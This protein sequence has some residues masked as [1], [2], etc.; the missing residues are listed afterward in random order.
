MPDIKKDFIDKYYHAAQIAAHGSKILPDTIIAAAALE[1]NFGRSG[2]SS[3]YN[4]FFGR[5]PEKSYTGKVVNMPTKEYNKNTKQFYTIQ[6]PFK[7]YPTPAD[8]F[9]DYV[10]LLSYS[11]RYEKVPQATNA[12]EQFAAIQAAGYATDPKYSSKLS[13][14][15]DGLKIYIP[16]V[17]LG[18]GFFVLIG[19]LWVLF[20]PNRTI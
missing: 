8:A 5:K 1:S 19:I 6:Q 11:K 13:S 10:K 3:Q 12:K 20:M 2:L 9:K 18:I 14:V 15:L 4:N 16:V 17:A 7:W